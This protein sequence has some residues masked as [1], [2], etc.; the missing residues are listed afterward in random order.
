[1]PTE[2]T[3]NQTSI[4]IAERWSIEQCSA[5]QDVTTELSK[6][7]ENDDSKGNI[8]C[9]YTHTFTNKGSQPIRLIYYDRYYPSDLY[10]QPSEWKSHTVIQPGELAGVRSNIFQNTFADDLPPR[11]ECFIFSLAFVYEIPECL[12]ISEGESFHIDIL[13]IAEEEPILAPC[14]L[15]SPVS[16]SDAVPDISEGLR[17]E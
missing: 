11:Y 9:A 12:W 8:S 17:Q 10:S 14:T 6:F 16:Y 13:H 2:N 4:D 7:I 15:I 5:I 3:G 1:M